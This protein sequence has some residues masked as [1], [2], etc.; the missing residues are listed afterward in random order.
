MLTTDLQISSPAKF[1]FSWLVSEKYGSVA[2]ET[3]ILKNMMILR[4]F[5]WAFLLDY[6]LRKWHHIE[7]QD[8][9]FAVCGHT[10]CISFL[11]LVISLI[12][13]WTGSCSVSQSQ[14]SYFWYEERGYTRSSSTEAFYWPT[15][16]LI[17]YQLLIGLVSYITP[18]FHYGV[19]RVQI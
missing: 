10:R 17:G 12:L 16:S 9:T 5:R 3:V 4:K 14:N 2:M 13:A 19:T 1:I 7:S 6:I 15:C 18:E 11:L 8:H